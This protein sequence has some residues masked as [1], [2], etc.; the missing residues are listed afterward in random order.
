LIG[1][2][3]T[4]IW[5]VGLATSKH[6]DSIWELLSIGLACFLVAA[7]LEIWTLS[8]QIAKIHDVNEFLAV[9]TEITKEGHELLEGTCASTYDDWVDQGKT[10]IAL[11]SSHY[12]QDFAYPFNQPTFGGN[13]KGKLE[14]LSAI[15]RDVRTSGL[16]S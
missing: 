16:I 7:L 15:K 11:Y 13:V 2:I 5:A 8:K 6:H 12:A 1:G 9:L 4:A 3:S 14:K 10:R